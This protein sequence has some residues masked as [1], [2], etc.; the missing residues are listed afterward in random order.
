MAAMVPL[1]DVDGWAL[2]GSQVTVAVG[3]ARDG[4]SL[5][6][7][8]EGLRD[9]FDGGALALGSRLVAGRPLDSELLVLA[10]VLRSPVADEAMP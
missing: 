7:G 5:V 3:A 2:P 1:R 9:A 4:A 10:S 6:G 8:V